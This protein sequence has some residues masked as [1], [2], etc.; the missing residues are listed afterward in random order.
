MIILYYLDIKG[1]I[2]VVV[3]PLISLMMNHR[4]KFLL[5]GMNTQIAKDAQK[6]EQAT[7]ATI[8]GLVQLVYTSPQCLLKN[9][10]FQNMLKLW[11][12]KK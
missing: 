5:K 1:G 7:E 11:Y 8:N 9:C 12:I 6:G 4:N 2:V 3:T 10:P